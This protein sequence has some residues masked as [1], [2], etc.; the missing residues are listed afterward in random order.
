[1]VVF[2]V[3]YVTFSKG[4]DYDRPPCELLTFWKTKYTLTKRIAT[5][6][7]QVQSLSPLTLLKVMMLPILLAIM[8]HGMFVIVSIGVSI[9]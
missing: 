8:S 3:L 1:M 4:R 7:H 6:M 5:H 9:N 2:R